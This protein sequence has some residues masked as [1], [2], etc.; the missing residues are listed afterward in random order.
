MLVKLDQ[1]TQEWLVSEC[2]PR[3]C[4][5][6]R[7]ANQRHQRLQRLPAARAVVFEP[8]PEGLQHR[9]LL[10]IEVIA[11][12]ECGDLF[13]RQ[14]HKRSLA[15]ALHEVRSNVACGP[16]VQCTRVLP[17]LSMGGSEGQRLARAA[18]LQAVDEEV[19]R[20]PLNHTHLQQVRGANHPTHRRVGEPQPS[21]VETVDDRRECRA[22][23]VF[24]L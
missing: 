18:W 22:L 8:R 21:R 10:R 20:G 23:R 19:A 12:D 2:Q 14:P 24:D 3:R 4:R 9:C 11:P 17:A 15:R 16:R 5:Q 7:P 6:E 1:S 13:A